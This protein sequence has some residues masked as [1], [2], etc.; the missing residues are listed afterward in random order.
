MSREIISCFI[1]NDQY[2]ADVERTYLYLSNYENEMK[3]S[4]FDIKDIYVKSRKLI[5]KQNTFPW[6]IT[7]EGDN[8]VCLYKKING[9]INQLR[10]DIRIGSLIIDN[11]EQVSSDWEC[12]IC[13]ENHQQE[14]LIKL[15]CCN[16][17][18]HKNCI[19]NYWKTNNTN[20][21]CPLCRSS[22]CPFC[23][24]KGTCV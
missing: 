9:S 20:S 15:L 12:S 13:L 1:N 18:Y 10:T 11:K 4:W 21:K 23:L 6:I 24:D 7:I 16:S 3:V 5:I 2:I 8:T 19:N 22:K 14:D 17:I